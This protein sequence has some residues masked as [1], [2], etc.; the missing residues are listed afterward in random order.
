MFVFPFSIK[1]L[2]FK[3]WGPLVD[4]NFLYF[5][6]TLMQLINLSYCKLASGNIQKITVLLLLQ[7]LI[8]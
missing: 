5:R 7:E 1:L 2:S 8:V 4:Y 3:Y 6:A